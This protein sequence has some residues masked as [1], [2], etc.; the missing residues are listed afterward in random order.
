MKSYKDLDIYKK[1][2]SLAVITHQ[3]TLSLP[4]HEKYEIGSQLRRASQSIKDNIVEG[5]GRRR[6]KNEFVRFLIFA[7]ASLLE[8]RSQLEMVNE[9]YSTPKSIELIIKYD[10]LGKMINSFQNYVQNQW[11]TSHNKPPKANNL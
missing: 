5:Y 6:Y 3:L 7:H 8:T 1:S 11:D 9:L 10:E 4:A 2:F